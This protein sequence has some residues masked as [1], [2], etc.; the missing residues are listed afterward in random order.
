MKRTAVILVV[1]VVAGLVAVGVWLTRIA[2]ELAT[3][4]GLAVWTLGV[5]IAGTLLGRLSSWQSW[6]VAPQGGPA[7]VE[8]IDYEQYAQM[9]AR[10]QRMPTDD[11]EAAVHAGPEADDEPPMPTGGV[12][13][14]V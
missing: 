13:S 8:G 9:I 1:V 11:E 6:I 4:V 14:G 3:G 2:P 5:F 10:A 7:P 12:A